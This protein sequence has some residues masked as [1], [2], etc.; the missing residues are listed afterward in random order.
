MI[1]VNANG[2]TIVFSALIIYTGSCEDYPVLLFGTSNGWALL[3]EQVGPH[4]DLCPAADSTGSS[5]PSPSI[6]LSLPP[7]SAIPESPTPMPVMSRTPAPTTTTE[8]SMPMSQETPAPTTT[9]GTLIPTPSLQE[10]PN[11]TTTPGT[12]IPTQLSQKTAAPTTITDTLIPTQLSQTIR[13]TMTRTQIPTMAPVKESTPTPGNKKM[14]CKH[15]KKDSPSKKSKK[16]SKS[17]KGGKGSEMSDHVSESGKGSK[18]SSSNSGK[19]DKKRRDKRK[20]KKKKK[21]KTNENEW[22][23]IWSRSGK[24]RLLNEMEKREIYFRVH[25]D[26]FR[27]RMVDVST[28][29]SISTTPP[30]VLEEAEYVA[31]YKEVFKD[32]E[33]YEIDVESDGLAPAFSPGAKIPS[34]DKPNLSSIAPASVSPI[35]SPLPTLHASSPD[36]ESTTAPTSAIMIPSASPTNVTDSFDDLVL[37]RA[38]MTL[39]DRSSMVNTTGTRAANSKRHR[40][41]MIHAWVILATFVGGTLLMSGL[42]IRWYGPRKPMWHIRI[43]DTASGSEEEESVESRLTDDKRMGV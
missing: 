38:N 24:R 34:P 10:T 9:S 5:S 15:I 41:L 37:E 31:I 7:I 3:T 32:V 43:P 1:G 39:E 26:V 4:A 16:V 21:N 22:G 36:T 35:V 12:L 40:K 8:T 25:G 33:C 19:K 6:A 20:R 29:N 14:I 27:E 18:S 23:N 11:P 42:L 28:N 2:G 17:G 13:P 30:G